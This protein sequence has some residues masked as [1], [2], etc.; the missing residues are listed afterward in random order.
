M[1][2]VFPLRGGR[3]IAYATVHLGDST[4]GE[5]NDKNFIVR[6]SPIVGGG[7]L[8]LLRRVDVSGYP[9]VALRVSA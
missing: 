7:T 5:G 2:G 4:Y 1:I 9:L 3:A 6:V 8:L